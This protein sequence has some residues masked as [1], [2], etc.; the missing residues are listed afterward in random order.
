MPDPLTLES[1]RQRLETI[2]KGL[3]HPPL[4]ASTALA[5][6]CGEAA[7]LLLDHHAYGAPLDRDALAGSR[8]AP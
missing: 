5:E 8:G 7:K 1:L 6:E 4:G 2:L 3:H